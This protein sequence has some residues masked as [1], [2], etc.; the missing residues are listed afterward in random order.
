MNCLEFRRRLG[1]E[2]ASTL[3]SF[4]A[5]RAECPSCAA[6]QTRADEFEERIRR[7]VS[8]PAPSNLADRI[9]LAQ[10]TVRVNYLVVINN[11]QPLQGH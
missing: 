7:A 4:V 2:P 3:G 9:L 8:V 1:S 5:H 10:I 6:A 11:V